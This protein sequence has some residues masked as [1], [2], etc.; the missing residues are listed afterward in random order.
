MYENLRQA[1]LTET[2]EDEEGSHLEIPLQGR[3]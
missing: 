1:L 2:E 3:K